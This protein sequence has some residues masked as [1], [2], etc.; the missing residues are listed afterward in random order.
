VRPCASFLQAKLLN[1]I[2]IQLVPILLGTPLLAGLPAGVAELER[3]RT[4]ATPA[5]THLRFLVR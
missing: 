3:A 4:I 5:A 2:Q 1:E